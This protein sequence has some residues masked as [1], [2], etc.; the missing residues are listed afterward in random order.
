[1]TDSSLDYFDAVKVKKYVRRSLG[2]LYK[3]KNIKGSAKRAVTGDQVLSHNESASCIIPDASHKIK[4]KRIPPRNKQNLDVLFQKSSELEKQKPIGSVSFQSSLNSKREYSWDSNK[5]NHLRKLSGKI[6]KKKSIPDTSNEKNT[7]CK[8]LGFSSLPSAS[9]NV[10]ITHTKTEMNSTPDT[11]LKTKMNSTPGTSLKTKVNSTPDTSL[12]TEM[13]STSGTSLKRRNNKRKRIKLKNTNNLVS[14]RYE[15]VSSLSDT[16]NSSGNSD[17]EDHRNK[18]CSIKNSRRLFVENHVKRPSTM[19]KVIDRPLSQ[20][21]SVSPVSDSSESCWDS[22]K[23]IQRIK[24]SLKTLPSSFRGKVGIKPILNPSHKKSI[25]CNELN[26]TNLSSTNISNF[27]VENKRKQCAEFQKSKQSTFKKDIDSLLSQ[28]ES[29]SPVSDS[30]SDSEKEIQQTKMFSKRKSSSLS[31]KFGNKPIL[32]L[33]HENNI[34]CKELD[35]SNLSSN[36]NKKNKHKQHV[37]F[38]SKSKQ[39]TKKKAIATVS[40][41]SENP[42]IDSSDMEIKP[43]KISRSTFDDTEKMQINSHV[44]PC[45]VKLRRIEF[46]LK[47][48]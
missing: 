36:V 11:S 29:V 43:I 10:S 1:M 27:H 13:N 28:S 25:V 12:K 21:E 22:D 26:L 20:S 23:E 14:Y 17:E 3:C 44:K 47:P 39:L 33:S 37:E 16:S 24:M 41:Q 32:A 45:F 38:Q 35:F 6:N 4:I 8:E 15:A 46:Q 5:E 7:I 34:A 19:R 31:G 2:R 30:C 9:F 42:V 18:V 40:S 48:N